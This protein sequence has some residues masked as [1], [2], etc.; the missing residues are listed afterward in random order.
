MSLASLSANVAPA[1]RT[2]A[3]RVRERLR[4][5]QVDPARDPDRAALIARAEVRRHN[6]YALGRGRE[7][8]DDEAAC[9]RDVLASVAGYGPLQA[10][11]DDPSVEEVWINAPDRVFVARD[12]RSERA[13]ARA[14]RRRRPR[15]RGADAA[16]HRPPRRPQPAVRRR[17]AAGRQSAA[18]RDPGHHPTPLGRQ[19]P[20]VPPRV[21]RA[22]RP[23]R[24]R[25]GDLRGRRPA[26][27]G[28]GGRAHGA[29]VRRDG[30]GQDDA[31]RGAHRG[32]SRAPPHRHGRGDVRA[33]RA[34]ARHRRDAG[35]AAEPRGD[36]RSDPPAPREGGAA[37]ATRPARRRGGA[38]RRG[39]RPPARPQHG[40][41]GCR[42]PAREL[43]ARRRCGSSPRC[44][45]WP[46]GTSTPG[47]SSPR[48]P[49]PSTSSC[50]AGGVPTAGASCRR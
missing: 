50:T 26:A 3:E 23:R 6:D 8:I 40:R 17:V 24:D 4:A 35:A 46:D 11:L 38:R 42:D 41:P 44:R 37:D 1:T 9:V 12:G 7:L 32:V 43:G 2:V 34:G 20:Q 25:L 28:D 39:T 45:C 16:R 47:S 5:D 49:R 14:H 27:G 33:R 21:S 48:S 19:H 29:G 31:S 10:L 36:R 13:P 22:G 18:R 15:S 30:S